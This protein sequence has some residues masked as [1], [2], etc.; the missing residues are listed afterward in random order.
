MPG[1]DTPPFKAGIAFYPYCYK[2]L[3]NLNFPLLILIG[4]KDERTPSSLCTERNTSRQTIYDFALK[5]YPGATHYFDVEG[6][7]SDDI[8]HRVRYDRAAAADTIVQV[9]RFLEVHLK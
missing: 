5:V 4:E 9:R 8:G 7:S 3:G 6:V 1:K 2:P